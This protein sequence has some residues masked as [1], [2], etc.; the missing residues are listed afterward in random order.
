MDELILPILILLFLVFVAYSFTKK[1]KKE[2]NELQMMKKNQ[3]VRKIVENAR[4]RNDLPC[5]SGFKFG[6]SLRHIEDMGVSYTHLS[7]NFGTDLYVIEGRFAPIKNDLI[8]S[9]FVDINSELGL[10]RITGNFFSTNNLD[11]IMEYY[12]R[13]LLEEYPEGIVNINDEMNLVLTLDEVIIQLSNI[14]SNISL[15]YSLIKSD[16]PEQLA[17][18]LKVQE[19]DKLG[20]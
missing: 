9:Y 18:M 12:K 8:E 4:I 16:T 3:E 2:E 11:F 19:K 10:T 17:E 7:R 13:L 1:S 5:L 14:E 6:L 15:I 20:I